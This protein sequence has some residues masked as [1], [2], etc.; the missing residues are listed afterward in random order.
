MPGRF[1]VPLFVE[2]DEKDPLTVTIGQRQLGITLDFLGCRPHHGVGDVRFPRLKH[3]E[4]GGVLWNAPHDECFD[5]WHL[6]PIAFISLQNQFDALFLAY[7]LI[8]TSADGMLLEAIVP[9]PLEILLRHNPPDT[10]RRRPK[11]RQEIWPG[12]F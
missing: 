5:V 2:D 1:G 4:A 7:K 6:T 8:G 10:R 3:R 12:L 11:V 9:D